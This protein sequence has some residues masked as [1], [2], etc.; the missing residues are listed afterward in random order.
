MSCSEFR[1]DLSPLVDNALEG[2]RA[3]LVWRHLHCCSECRSEFNQLQAMRTMLSEAGRVAPP[4]DLALAIRLRISRETSM[5]W[6]ERLRLRVQ[7]MLQPLAVPALAGICSAFFMFAVLI[8]SFAIPRITYVSD[9]V[10]LYLLTTSARATSMASLDGIKTD[11]QGIYIEVQVDA[12]GRVADFHLLTPVKDPQTLAKIQ[13][14]LIFMRFEPA[15]TFG[16]PRSGSAV[17][18]Y[19]NISIKG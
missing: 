3:V 5:N 16:I 8:H 19:T 6:A 7:D 18:S 11:D 1:P 4:E 15:T 12:A 10:P 14:A 9:D 2:Q 17:L 13:N